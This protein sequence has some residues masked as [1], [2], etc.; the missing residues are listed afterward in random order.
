MADTS[1]CVLAAGAAALASYGLGQVGVWMLRVPTRSVW[2]NVAV[3]AGLGSAVWCLAFALLII[4]GALS[5]DVV[6]LLTLGCAAVGVWGLAA[7]W[8]RL[9]IAA[10]AGSPWSSTE[11]QWPA[12][13]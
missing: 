10:Q 1:S 12:T 7:C 9:R 2:E 4:L 11:K 13:A 3:S 5:V 8:I 6:D